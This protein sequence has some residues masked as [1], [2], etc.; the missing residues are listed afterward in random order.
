MDFVGLSAGRK[1]H[2]DEIAPAVAGTPLKMPHQL[3]PPSRQQQHQPLQLGSPSHEHHF[4][5]MQTQLQQGQYH[6]GM[7]ASMNST[8]AHALPDGRMRHGYLNMM[9][10]Q[11]KSPRKAPT[12]TRRMSMEFFD[13]FEMKTPVMLQKRECH[14]V[15]METTRNVPPGE[16]C[17]G[18]W[19]APPGV[20]QASLVGNAPLC[21]PRE[22]AEMAP[23]RPLVPPPKAASVEQKE[24]CTPCP[25]RVAKPL[26]KRAY[27]LAP[28]CAPV[29]EP[30]LPAVSKRYLVMCS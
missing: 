25:P 28:V 10:V 15:L 29:A 18:E 23:T 1:R 14:D 27:L 21:R 22:D 2:L 5:Q 16:R 11:N 20:L 9:D 24:N 26:A 6:G 12:K 17:S 8:P 3:S 30:A 7:V 4:E 13:D 19:D